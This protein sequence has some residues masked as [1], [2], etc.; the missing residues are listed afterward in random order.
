M[1]NDSEMQV[2]MK[3]RDTSGSSEASHGKVRSIFHG[4][5]SR[6]VAAG[7]Q[8]R[9]RGAHEREELFARL[10]VVPEP[11]QH[12]RRDRLGVDLLHAAHH[13]AHVP[14]ETTI[15]SYSQ[16]FRLRT[17][18]STLKGRTFSVMSGLFSTK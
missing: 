15:E 3:R 4:T 12:G 6:S 9:S 2:L 13:H 17:R 18:G 14:E 7:A 11:A 1:M 16:L 10:R 5:A 8:P